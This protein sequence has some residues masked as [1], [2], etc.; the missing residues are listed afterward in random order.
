MK[1]LLLIRSL[2]Y[3]G[4]ERQLVNLATGSQ[5]QGR[6]V[7]VA[8]FYRGGHLQQEL[9]EAGV[10][11]LWLGKRSRWNIM[12]PLLR[13]V[14]LVK[15]TRPA[16]VYSWMPLANIVATLTKPFLPGKTRVVWGVRAS[17]MDLNRY[18]W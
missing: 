7:R 11:V 14:T 12:G 3:G 9:E 8:V 18:N 4:A 1:I 2:T 10:T 6:D 13:F 17:N 5:E 16:V 15:A